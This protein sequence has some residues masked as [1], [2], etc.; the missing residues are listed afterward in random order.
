MADAKT[1]PLSTTPPEPSAAA[2]RST[3]TP[4]ARFSQ[5]AAHTGLWRRIAML[6]IIAALASGFATYGALTGSIS[7]GLGMQT[8]PVLLY[9]DLVLVLLLCVIVIMRVVQLG[10]ERRRGS[11]GSRLHIKLA[12]LFSV[13]AVAPAIIVAVFSV[14]FLNIG[15]ESWFSERVR[16]ALDASLAVAEA[17]IEEHRKNIRGDALA[18]ANDINRS[19]TM[20]LQN[21]ARFNRFLETQA[22]IRVLTEVMVFR[23]DG[24][25]FGRSGLTFSLLLERIPYQALREVQNGGVFIL[26]SDSDDRVRALTRI[27]GSADAY[28]LVGRLVDARAIGHMER[29]QRA[30][31]EYK[32]LE[33]Q[34]SG[35]QITFGLIFGL[36]ALLLLLASVWVGL[37]FATRLGRPISN[38]IAA[39]ERIRSGDLA[40]RVE[41]GPA[42][43]EIS[44]LSRAFNRMIGQLD[45][46]RQELIETNQ[47]LDTRR[48]FTESVLSGVTAGVIGLDSSSRVEL[49]NPSALTLLS[50]RTSEL[51]GRELAEVVPEMAA[52]MK[53][54]MNRPSRRAEAQVTIIRQGRSLNLLVRISAERSTGELEGFVVTFDDITAL[55]AAQRTAAWADVAQRIAHEIK[56]P[57]TPIQLSAERIKRKYLKHITSEVDVFTSCIETIERQVG[58]IGRMI[59][60]FSSF[61]RMPAPVFKGEDAIELLRQAITLQEVAH[62]GIEFSVDAPEDP[63]N[64]RCDGQ[65]VV[66]VLTNVLKN[67]AESID[68]RDAPRSGDPGRIAVTLA[69]TDDHVEIMVLDNGRGLPAG[70]RERLVEPYITTRAKGTGLGLAIV[71]KIMEDHGG[72]LTIE[73]GAE[74]GALIRLIFPAAGPVAE[75]KPARDMEPPKVAIHGA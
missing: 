61:A 56:N 38:L 18:L 44:S 47:Q 31:S 65:Q 20:L 39:A 62:P 35:I 25:I 59:D 14:L 42:D 43:D 1:P 33:G 57:L 53:E 54:A 4:W 16:T 11:A 48:R 75:T 70:L 68:A 13:V 40:V 32:R 19:S 71:K 7:I 9:I 63:V 15:L 46:Q 45:S 23:P 21:Q 22:A 55:L 27:K 49:P 6:I 64:L 60:E 30:V 5:W 36:V 34:R 66:Q 74:S 10:V 67:A 73:D 2:V 51:I 17:Y 12:T 8:V 28:L 37:S 3:P 26:S 72:E 52:L 58:I 69:A 50:A 41:E 29:T 24:K